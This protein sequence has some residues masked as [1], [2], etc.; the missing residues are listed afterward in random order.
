[1]KILFLT[2][3]LMLMMLRGELIYELKEE[4]KCKFDYEVQN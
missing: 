2:E 4:L 1:M 3:C